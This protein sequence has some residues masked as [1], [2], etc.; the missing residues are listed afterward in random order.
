VAADG[1]KDKFPKRPRE[2]SVVDLDECDILTAPLQS[3]GSPA[4]FLF[5]Q[6][7]ATTL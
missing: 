7:S 2:E 4:T 3:R 6:A 1:P 5:L